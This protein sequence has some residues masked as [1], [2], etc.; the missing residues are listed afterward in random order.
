LQEVFYLPRPDEPIESFETKERLAVFS[1]LSMLWLAFVNKANSSD[2][3]NERTAVLEGIAASSSPAVATRLQ[4][5][6]ISR[7]LEGQATKSYLLLLY[8]RIG[9]LLSGTILASGSST[10]G[11]VTE[12]LLLLLAATASQAGR[13]TFASLW[14]Q[15]RREGERLAKKADR[16]GTEENHR[17]NLENGASVVGMIEHVVQTALERNGSDLLNE[18]RSNK[19]WQGLMEFWLG[20][21]RAVSQC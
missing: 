12:H 2:K 10:D 21:Y 1:W 19:E 5:L 7:C 6:D 18:W 8:T 14:S 13:V 16:M 17:L 3:Q 4:A 11:D 15:T 9:K 20:L